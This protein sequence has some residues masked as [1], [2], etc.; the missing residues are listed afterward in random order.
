MPKRQGIY[1]EM[2][3]AKSKKLADKNPVGQSPQLGSLIPPTVPEKAGQLHGL[4]PQVKQFHHPQVK[5][6]HGYGHTASLKHGHLRLSGIAEAHR[7][8]APKKMKLK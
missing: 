4:G 5:G 3:L 2:P 6:A 8:G 1:A 7:I